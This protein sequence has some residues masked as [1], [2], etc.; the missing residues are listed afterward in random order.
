MCKNPLLSLSIVAIVVLLLWPRVVAAQPLT[1][2]NDHPEAGGEDVSL[3]FLVGTDLCQTACTVAMK[4]LLAMMREIRNAETIPAV[5]YVAGARRRT[6]EELARS[7][8]FPLADSLPTDVAALTRGMHMPIAVLRS[9][10]NRYVIM[11]N[12]SRYDKGDLEMLLRSSAAVAS[13]GSPYV[14]QKPISC[15]DSLS[16]SGFQ[17]LS[18][19]TLFVYDNISEAAAVVDIIRDTITRFAR[20]PDAVRYR[21]RTAQNERYWNGYQQAGV[22]MTSMYCAYINGVS[23][24][25][26]TFCLS[27]M[28]VIEDTTQRSG[29][30]SGEVPTRLKGTGS[31]WLSVTPSVELADSTDGSHVFPHRNGI[32]GFA[33]QRLSAVTILSGGT[34]DFE[35]TNPDSQSIV[36]CVRDGIEYP[37]VTRSHVNNDNGKSD[38]FNFRGYTAISDIQQG[39][40]LLANARN[41]MFGIYDT[42]TQTI[43]S[44]NPT[45]P[46]ASVCSSAMFTSQFPSYVGPELLV[47]PETN[48][49]IAITY[50]SVDELAPSNKLGVIV[51][52]FD[53]EGEHLHTKVF[54]E[55]MEKRVQK[56]WFCHVSNGHLIGLNETESGFELIRLKL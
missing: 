51:S 18:D 7:I 15:L 45:G 11:D 55:P 32:F 23:H 31:R 28:Q 14:Q 50:R 48:T 44:I 53:A 22:R 16:L 41:E 19:S 24:D 39:R 12:L 27:Q 30:G 25:S 36:V 2:P 38:N 6:A 47:D 40:V 46:L 43:R 56:L 42:R 5:V 3:I 8:G 34:K 54:D 4:N 1:P 13:S 20:L 49:F 17:A 21:Y 9:T 52:A 10:A 37:L 33:R 26:I 29:D 35:S